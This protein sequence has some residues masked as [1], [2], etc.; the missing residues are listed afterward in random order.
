ML[1]AQDDGN[2]TVILPGEIAIGSY[3]SVLKVAKA[4]DTSAVVMNCAGT[5]LHSFLP[6]TLNDFNRLRTA[7]P[8]RLL[9]I[10]WE[11]SLDFEITWSDV[12]RGLLWARDQVERGRMVVVNCAQG[13]SRSGT[14]ATA[15]I[16]AKLKL[17]AGDALALIKEKRP[18][19]EPNPTFMRRLVALEAQIHKLYPDRT[20]RDRE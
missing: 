16:M 8:C 7:T 15:Y 17:S 13:K 3:K 19:V 20:Q 11:D 4:K 10:E 12:E 6:A 1:N 18:I 14:M 5:R 2:P 9:D